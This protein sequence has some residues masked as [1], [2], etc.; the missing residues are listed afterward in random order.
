MCYLLTLEEWE[1]TIK[2]A[3]QRGFDNKV[4]FLGLQETK[5]HNVNR[6]L[7][8]SLWHNTPFDYVAKKSDGRSGGII[9]VKDTMAFSLLSSM[10]GDG[11]IAILGKW[12]NIDSPCLIIVVYSPQEQRKGQALVGSHSNNLAPQFSFH[13]A[14]RLQ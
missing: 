13:C 12:I 1:K 8:Q 10:E 9:A 4:K 5:S 2:E 6:S 3:G 14:R 7:I 11:F